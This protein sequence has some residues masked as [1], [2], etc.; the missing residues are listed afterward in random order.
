MYD[1]IEIDL[2][3]QDVIALCRGL[4]AQRELFREYYPDNG[5]QDNI[6]IQLDP[7]DIARV[8]KEY[9]SS[10]G[11]VRSPELKLAVEKISE[12]FYDAGWGFDDD[13]LVPP[14]K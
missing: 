8:I 3:A 5:C 6:Q 10:Q 7:E 12:T 1:V 2:S 11:V 9:Y 14:T 4:T 13:E